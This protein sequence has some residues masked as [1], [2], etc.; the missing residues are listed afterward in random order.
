M[1][2][3]TPGS[4]NCYSRHLYSLGSIDIYNYSSST[5]ESAWIESINFGWPTIKRLDLSDVWIWIQ[6]LK[7]TGRQIA[8]NSTD[9]SL[10]S[11]LNICREENVN[12][13]QLIWVSS[14][15]E[16][17]YDTPKGQISKTLVDRIILFLGVPENGKRKF[18]KRIRELYDLRSRFV[19]GELEVAHPVY[20]LNPLENINEYE[21]ILISNI[22]FGVSIIIATLQ[23]MIE[24]KWTKIK[25]YEQI[26]GE[27]Y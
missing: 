17:L 18:K 9:S 22:D 27:Q 23:K 14:A 19:H 16:G 2:I 4:F 24:M 12:P 13:T 20:K 25:F 3:S 11:I 6:Q 10:F 26:Q 7:L 5:I 8:F 21:G 15:L 1:N